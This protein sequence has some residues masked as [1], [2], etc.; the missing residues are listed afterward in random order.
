MKPIAAISLLAIFCASCHNGTKKNNSDDTGKMG[1]PTIDLSYKILKKIKIGGEGGWDYCA[2]DTV[3]RRLFISHSTKV[4]V[5]DVD[6]EKVIGEIPNT[7]GVHGIAFDYELNKGYTSNGKDS[8]VT[9]FDLKSLK[10]LKKITVTGSN[11]DCIIF[12][13][14]SKHIFTFNGKSNNTTVIDAQTD[15]VIATIALI[16]KP[17]FAISDMNGKVVVNLEDANKFAVIDSKADTMIYNWDLDTALKEPSGLSF[18]LAYKCMFVGCGNKKMGMVPLNNFRA[19]WMGPIGE[20]VDAT[21]FNSKEG[22][23]FASCGDG[24]LSIT[25]ELGQDTCCKPFVLTTQKGARTMAIDERKDRVYLPVADFGPPAAAE[26]GKKPKPGVIPG[27]FS[28]IVVG[29]K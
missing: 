19:R 24:T 15:K 7:P 12:D 10:V 23:A 13:P 18:D 11:P 26:P 22:E 21:A 17:E 9:V 1:L 6:A 20:H 2:F 16:G 14:F 3:N 27:T 28:I 8:S 25:K 5:L 29:R 4:D